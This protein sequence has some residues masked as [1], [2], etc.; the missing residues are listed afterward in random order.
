MLS[1]VQGTIL[2]LYQGLEHSLG[3]SET[4]Y[5]LINLQFCY[6]SKYEC[7]ETRATHSDPGSEGSLLLKVDGDADDGGEVDE[8]E[9]EASEDADGE[10]EDDDRGCC[11]GECQT[12]CC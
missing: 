4:Q 8:A 7:S 9:P 1:I 2:T 10:V 6:R 5:H 11:Q 12:S 3:D